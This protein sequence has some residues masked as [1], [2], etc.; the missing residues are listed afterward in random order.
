MTTEPVSPFPPGFAIATPRLQIHPF[1]P[2]NSSHCEF[3]VKL[4]N[5][6]DFIN[7]SGRTGI[8]TTEKAAAFIRRRVLADYA[9][10]RHGQ[11]LVS[12]VEATHPPKLIGCVSLMKGSPPGPHYLAPDV[13]YTIL[14]ED[15]GKGYATEASKGLLEYARVELGIHAAFGFCA[16]TDMRSR[17]VLEKIGMDYRGVA[18]LS[19]FGGKESAVY[20][21]HGMDKDLSVYNLTEDLCDKQSDI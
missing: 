17:R 3:L 10:N 7:S 16:A 20:T 5:T 14:P 12:L 6:D 19:V 2:D 8:D 11:F 13:G 21:L 4:W 15:I 18:A 9:R 1:D